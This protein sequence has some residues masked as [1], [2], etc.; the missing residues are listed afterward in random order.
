MHRCL[1]I[2]PCARGRPRGIPA[3]RPEVVRSPA[4]AVDL[5]HGLQ[6]AGFDFGMWL[7]EVLTSKSWS[8]IRDI[9]DTSLCVH[10]IVLLVGF[11][12]MLI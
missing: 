7:R 5:V 8:W 9:G 4:A 1:I 11:I 2:D 12:D 6:R 3:F 10:N